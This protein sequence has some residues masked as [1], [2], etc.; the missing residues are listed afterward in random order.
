[1]ETPQEAVA[2]VAL[3]Q[4]RDFSRPSFSVVVTHFINIF[5]N[6]FLHAADEPDVSRLFQ[7]V[8]APS[9]VGEPGLWALH[10]TQEQW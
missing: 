10:E 6:C 3:L 9:F 7:R 4:A 5:S 8:M 2:L 1:M